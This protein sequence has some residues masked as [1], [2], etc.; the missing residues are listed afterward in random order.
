MPGTGRWC[1]VQYAGGRL[2]FWGISS[3]PSIP[4]HQA[5][6]LVYHSTDAHGR[7]LLVLSRLY[8]VHFGY[9]LTALQLVCLPA[10]KPDRR[11]CPKRPAGSS[12]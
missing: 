8:E 1:S 4:T 7:N 6:A 12:K 5:H 2:N 9:V 11:C 3:P 10:L